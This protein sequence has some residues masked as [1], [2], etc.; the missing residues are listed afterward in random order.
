MCPRMSGPV[1]V[2]GVR[3]ARR[4][5]LALVLALA[6]FIAGFFVHFHTAQPST[7]FKLVNADP[8]IAYFVGTLAVHDGQP[9]VYVPHPGTP[10]LVLGTLVILLVWPFTASTVDG[11][12]ARLVQEP[13]IF[14]VPAH[15]VLVLANLACVAA[16]GWKALSVRRGSDAVLAAAV[17]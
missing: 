6:V 8:E 1:T 2:T 16:L 14:I 17:P 4:A 10:F 15:A 12:I 9:Y 5:R 7:E 3:R 13:E 11:L